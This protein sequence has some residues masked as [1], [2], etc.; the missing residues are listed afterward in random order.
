MKF[1]CT[2][3][4]N[5]CA[6]LTKNKRNVNKLLVYIPELRCLGI[7]IGNE[8]GNVPIKYCP[9]CGTKQPQELSYEY[10]ETIINEIGPEYYP[11]DENYDPDRPLPNEFLTSEWWKKRGL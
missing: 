5:E 7:A 9:F 2:S 1:C 8:G 3:L 11:A 10:W 6:V 4:K